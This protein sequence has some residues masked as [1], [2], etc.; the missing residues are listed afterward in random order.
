ML[1]QD[2]LSQLRDLKS[3]IEAE[4]ERAEA[5]VKGTQSRYGF[6]VLDDGREIFIPPDE[7][8]KVFPDDR[9]QVCIRPTRDNKTI[10]DVE[11][12]IDSP[13]GE[14][15]G[16]CVRKG[17]AIFVEP[18]LAQ[19]NRWLF[20]PPH[21]RN[22]VKEGD[23]LRCAILRHPIRD[24]KPQAKVLTI[25]GNEQT[26]GIENLYS[27][28]KYALAAQW[29]DACG[30]EVEQLLADCRPMEQERRRDLTDL[31]FIS[32]DTVKTQDIDDAL[33]AE[34][35]SDGWTLFVA[36]A[37]P[38]AYIP[39]DSALHRDIAAR[40]TTVYFHGDVL[41]MMPE[42]LA[43]DTCALSEGC[44]RPALVCKIA[45]SDSG[46]VGDFEFIEATVRSRA[47][48]SYYG[49]DRYL[50]GHADDLMS[51]ATPLEALYQVFRALR[52][53]RETHGLVMEERREFRWILNDDKRID[54]IE[55]YEKLLSQKL[56]E[57]CMVAANRC[58]ALFLQRGAANGPFVTHPG[59]RAD[60]LEE[61][62]QF[63]A[64]H[65]PEVAETDP[66]TV[67]GYRD[68]MRCLAR[69]DHPLPLRSM[70]N[71]L[72]T[73]AELSASPGPHMG[74]ALEVYTNCTS[75]LRKYVDFLVHLQ[76]KALLHGDQATQ[77]STTLLE[78]LAQRLANTRQA[79]LEAERWLAGKYL[80]RLAAEG[81][82]TFKAT[83]SHINSSGFN[84]RLDDN[85]LEGF[86]DLRKDPE[87]FSY[88]KW[89]ASLTSTTRRFQLEQAVELR[90]REVDRADQYR[91]LFEVVEGC[92]LKPQKP[93]PAQI[94]TPE[95]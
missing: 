62:R 34:I 53:H 17:K 57:E 33:Y 67:T 27:M 93:A 26:P 35:S 82:R 71:R 66:T 60:R 51:H 8:L 13:L 80:A 10:A 81:E 91:A 70:I 95:P 5:V 43:Q 2:A 4:K 37:D 68:I 12:L 79:T 31:E 55:P 24:G 29:S 78:R 58:A 40:G 90:F 6:A 9:I 44:D 92:G 84:V 11:K 30:K 89:T 77:V 46:E 73:R 22:G 83:V 38:T 16:R 28:A 76:I 74:M 41:P 15:T 45:V 72:L 23:Y 56:V 65:A 64:M 39:R 3:R 20:I 61:A 1:N 48:L 59:I 88:D 54:T 94:P 25:I 63:L 36:I 7:M 75:P 42:Q 47:K 52:G 69:G 87:K 49:V 14:F 21:A 86:V 18:D 50:N 32:I 85:G 19:L